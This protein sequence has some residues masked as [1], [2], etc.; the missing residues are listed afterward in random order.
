MPYESQISEGVFVHDA[1]QK[2]R[3]FRDITVPNVSRDSAVSIATDY[4][5][6]GGGVGV[7]VPVRS[8]FSLL[9]IVQTDS[10]AQPASYPMGTRGSFPEGKV[11]G[12][13][14]YHSPPTSAEVKKMWIYTSTPPHCLMV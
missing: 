7:R 8:E 3:I 6:D 11:A 2:V 14:A 1:H 12:H 13:E 5:V 4:G 10:G 9:H